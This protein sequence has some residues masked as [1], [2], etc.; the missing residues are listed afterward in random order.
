MSKD[1][2]AKSAVPHEVTFYTYPK[3][4]FAW[5]VIAAGFLFWLLGQWEWPNLEILAWAWAIVLFLTILTMGIDLSRNV[6]V[7]WMVLIV[8]I[9]LAIIY[10]RDVSGL[11]IFQ[12]TYNMFADLDPQYSPSLGLI[13]SITLTIPFLV[14]IFWSRINSRWRVTHNEFE[15]YSLGRAAR[16]G[17]QPGSSRRVYG[18]AYGVIF[19]TAA[20]GSPRA[21]KA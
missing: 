19:T 11:T 9:W 5:P 6:A 14:M 1:K 21:R 4:V 20:V 13:V 17:W 15:H 18:C 10:L 2:K 12:S 3:L 7:F 8:A 16:V